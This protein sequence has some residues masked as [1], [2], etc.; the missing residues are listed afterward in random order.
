MTILRKRE[1][2]RRAFAAFDADAVAR[3]DDTDVARLMADTSIVR[4]RMKIESTIANA[5]AILALREAGESLDDFL[6]RFVEGKPVQNR[7]RSLSELPAETPASKAM[8]KELKKRGFRFLGP[9]TCYAFMQ[10]VGM[11]NDHTLDCYRH[12]EVAADKGN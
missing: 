12:A 7:W 1:G 9:T 10:A 3:F 8:S 6:W 2:Y 5:R 4:N 11:V